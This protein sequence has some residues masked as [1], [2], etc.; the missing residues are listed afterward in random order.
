MFKLTEKQA[1]AFRA[2]LLKGPDRNVITDVGYF[3][4]W[5]S[6]VELTFTNLLAFVSGMRDLTTFDI[7][8]AGMDM[9]VKIERFRRIQKKRG[10]IG[11]NLD[12]RLTYLDQKC[13]PIRN[14]LAHC[15]VAQ[16]EK[17]AGCYLASTL[18]TMP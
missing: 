18:S 1:V 5:Y 12:T 11:P 7:L 9:R 10:G 8:S 13:R 17:Q 6:T 2:E 14:R 16:S 4:I 3:L 15:A